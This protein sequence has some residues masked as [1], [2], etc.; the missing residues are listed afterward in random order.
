MTA[1]QEAKLDAV[2]QKLDLIY[3]QVLKI[4]GALEMIDLSGLTAELNETNQALSAIWA[5][6][7]HRPDPEA[8]KF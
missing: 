5:Q 2:N 8:P 1:E 4:A 3:A 7:K 6:M